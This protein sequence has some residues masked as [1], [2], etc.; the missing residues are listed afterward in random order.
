M[1]LLVGYTWL[2]VAETTW[3]PGQYVEIYIY[4]G[5][6]LFTTLDIW[7]AQSTTT[8]DNWVNLSGIGVVPL[9]QGSALSIRLKHTNSSNLS[10]TNSAFVTITKIAYLAV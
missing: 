2:I 4:V 6:T 3:S 7:V 1:H 9:S 10:K 5:E 8:S